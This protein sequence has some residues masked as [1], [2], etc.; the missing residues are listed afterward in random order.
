PH[1]AEN[2]ETGGSLLDLKIHQAPQTGFVDLPLGIKGGRHNVDN[3]R[4]LHRHGPS[5]LPFSLIRLS[6]CPGS[7][8]FRPGRAPAP[9]RAPPWTLSPTRGPILDGPPANPSRPQAPLCQA[10]SPPLPATLP[11][12]SPGVFHPRRAEEATA[13]MMWLRRLVN[14][15]R[16][17]GRDREPGPSTPSRGDG[18]LLE[19]L[20]QQFQRSPDVKFNTFRLGET[21]PE[22][23][24]VYVEGLVDAAR[25]EE[26]TL[27]PI[28]SWAQHGRGIRGAV[29][30]SQ[31]AI[32]LRTLQ[33]QVLPAMEARLIDDLE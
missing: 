32:N 17:T 8:R 15:G 1:N 26:T 10:Y 3:T 33:E 16:R 5:S 12:G 31:P 14:G 30:G 4:K 6:G 9:P 19:R 23:V 28:L 21:G 24:A 11:S 7:Y 20:R 18:D 13:P 2:V 22:G 25:L 29:P 27:R